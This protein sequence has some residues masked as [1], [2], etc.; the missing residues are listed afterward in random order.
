[1]EYAKKK[2]RELQAAKI[3]R[4]PALD[5]RS[6]SSS[7][8]HDFTLLKVSHELWFDNFPQ[9]RRLISYHRY[10]HRNALLDWTQIFPPQLNP[11][12]FLLPPKENNFFVCYSMWK[13]KNPC[14][15]ASKEP[16]SFLFLKLS[17]PD[18]PT[19]SCLSSSKSLP[20]FFFKEK[21]KP[22]AR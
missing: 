7:Q 17:N 15:K 6:F 16:F 18:F 20:I 14:F 3:Q 10:T 8:T 2:T 4:D 11:F 1:M 12:L 22:R 13:K 19:F 21:K 9:E 5:S